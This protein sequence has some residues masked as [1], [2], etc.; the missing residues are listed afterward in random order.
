M[1][2]L[3]QLRNAIQRLTPVASILLV[4]AVLWLSAVILTTFP[5]LA[6]SKTSFTLNLGTLANSANQSGLLRDFILIPIFISTIGIINLLNSFFSFRRAPEMPYL[7]FISTIILMFYFIFTI[8]YSTNRF[9]DLAA[10]SHYP[11]SSDLSHD[12]DI[13]AN[14]FWAGLMAEAVIAIRQAGIKVRAG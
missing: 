5:I 14:T 8:L 2:A 4:R 10:L 12:V 13:V 7:F 1:P 3:I 9:S 11:T 6:S